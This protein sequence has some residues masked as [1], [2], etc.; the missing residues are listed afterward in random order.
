MFTYTLLHPISIGTQIDHI[1][2]HARPIRR[3]HQENGQRFILL[4]NF[5]QEQCTACFSWGFPGFVLTFKT[6]VEN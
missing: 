5:Y 6:E 4:A 2:Q 3:G 1:L